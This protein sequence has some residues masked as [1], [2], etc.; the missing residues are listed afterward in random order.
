VTAVAGVAALTIVIM[1]L[2]MRP[3]KP[4]AAALSV[5]LGWLVCYAHFLNRECEWL[6]EPF[7]NSKHTEHSLDDAATPAAVL[8]AQG[9][10]N[11]QHATNI[12]HGACDAQSFVASCMNLSQPAM[13]TVLAGSIANEC[14]R[15]AELLQMYRK[16][17]GS[18]EGASAPTTTVAEAIHARLILPEA[19]NLSDTQQTMLQSTQP[20]EGRSRRGSGIVSYPFWRPSQSQE[21]SP[22]PARVNSDLLGGRQPSEQGSMAGAPVLFGRQPSDQASM[23]GTPMSMF[24]H[25]PS[26]EFDMCTGS[27]SHRSSRRPSQANTRSVC[28]S[29]TPSNRSHLGPAVNSPSSPLRSATP[30]GD[31]SS[32]EAET[33][34][35]SESTSGNPNVQEDSMR[36]MPPWL[37][38][39]H[40]SLKG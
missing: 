2:V 23:L 40:A 20:W 1:A 31:S 26:T 19:Q 39:V 29:P 28:A 34:I 25:W 15:C 38:H 36:S 4:V 21:L 8:D 10:S 32:K 7:V 13:H 14:L 16:H 24:G 37:R 3:V 9:P 12:Y 17:F 22:G 11:D 35:A 30:V 33:V 5:L 18:L 6:V 27:P